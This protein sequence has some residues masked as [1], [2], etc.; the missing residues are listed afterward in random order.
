MIDGRGAGNEQN[1]R[2]MLQQ[3]GEC[4][5]YRSRVERL[6][7][8]GQRVRLQRRKATER[9]ERRVGKV[10]PGEFVDERVVENYPTL[11]VSETKYTKLVSQVGE[12]TETHEKIIAAG[13]SI[14]EA[15]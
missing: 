13:K 9:E 11:V 1:V 14:S 2:R 3:P 10:L 5:L 8:R 12:R 4:Y 15:E 7:G 6:R